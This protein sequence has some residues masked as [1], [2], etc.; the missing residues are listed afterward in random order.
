MAS[1]RRRPPDLIRDDPC[2]FETRF[3]K[4]LPAR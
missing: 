3:K 4:T 1:G 2:F